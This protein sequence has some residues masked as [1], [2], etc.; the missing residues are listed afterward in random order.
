MPFDY[1]HFYCLSS[2]RG[3]S[4]PCTVKAHKTI[5]Y[6]VA[7]E[8]T[9][10]NH[11]LE[12]AVLLKPS[13]RGQFYDQL[14][15][16]PVLL[17]IWSDK[18][19]AA[20]KRNKCTGWVA[21]SIKMEGRVD[22]PANGYFGISVVGRAGPTKKELARPLS[23]LPHGY[24]SADAENAISGYCGQVFDPS[25]WDG[26]DIFLCGKSLVVFVHR[27]VL[28]VFEEAKLS[29]FQFSPIDQI[30]TNDAEWLR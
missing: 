11:Q 27:R 29:G 12:Q 22:T 18:T 2:A 30:I 9:R 21:Y 17:K 1:S 24:T 23:I 7:A 16:D 14:E 4:A 20:L 5:T 3:R 8:L 10:G 19:I 26:S 15:A 13:K 25:T 28:D 6:P